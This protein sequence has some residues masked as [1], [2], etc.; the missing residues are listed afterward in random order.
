MEQFI[1]QFKKGSKKFRKVLTHSKLVNVPHN[2]QKF[3]ELTETII[4]L[5]MSMKLNEAWNCSFLKNEIR[6]FIFK[7]HN[8]T[9]GYNYRVSKF[10]AN[11]E[12]YCT[13]CTIQRRQDLPRETPLHI[14]LECPSVENLITN[15]INQIRGSREEIRR[16]DYFVMF[17]YENNHK[18]K[19]LTLLSHICRYYIWEMKQRKSMPELNEMKKFVQLEVLMLM[20][21]NDFKTS[22]R[23]SQLPGL[24]MED[25]LTRDLF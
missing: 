7:F 22:Y 5:E 17:E 2:I 25:Q 10:V 13:F 3:A 20:H 11:I 4:G 24:T 1:R 15:F 21:N 6:T 18:N 12:P 19:I 8:N 9:L 23:L 16:R 14:F